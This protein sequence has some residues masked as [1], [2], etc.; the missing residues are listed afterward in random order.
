MG[1]V[2]SKHGIPV[3]PALDHSDRIGEQGTGAGGIASFSLRYGDALGDAEKK[4]FGSDSFGS[5]ESRKNSFVLTHSLGFRLSSLHKHLEGELVAAGW[6]AW[7]SAVAGEAIHGWVPRR[8]DSF[9]KLDKI[10]QGTYSNVFRA[11]EVDTG[12]IVALKKVRFDIHEPESVRFMAREIQILRRLDH[13]NIVKLEGLIA[14][15]LSCSVYLVF[16]YMDHDLAGLS[17]CPNIQFSESQVKCYMHQLLCGLE[18]CHSRGVMHRDIKCAN[19]LVN[20]DGTL[21]IADFGLSNFWKQGK[22][23]P[24]TSRVVTLWYRPP[25]LLL[26]STDYGA[27]VDLWSVGCV[28][29]ELLLRKPILPGRTEVINLSYSLFFL[30]YLQ[31]LLRPY[32]CSPCRF[33]TY[34][35]NVI[36]PAFM[37]VVSLRILTSNLG[38]S[39]M[40]WVEQL[41]KIFKLCGSPPDEYWKKS[42]LPHATIFK[43]HQ[44]YESCLKDACKALP[45]SAFKLIETLLSVEPCKRGTATSALQSKYFTTVPYACEPSSLP[46]YAPNKEMDART[47]ELACRKRIV[48]KRGPDAVL[49]ASKTCKPPQGSNTL[50][51]LAPHAEELRTNTGEVRNSSL[52]LPNKVSDSRLSVDQQPVP[53]SKPAEETSHLKHNCRQDSIPF[54]GPLLVPPSGGFAWA[55]R[56]KEGKASRRSNSRS[57]S[58]GHDSRTV[59]PSRNSPDSRGLPERKLPG[60]DVIG[61]GGHDL[62]EMVKR[63]VMKQWTKLECPDSFDASD[64]FPSQDLSQA[65]YMKDEMSS[66]RSYM[67][68]RK[69][70]GDAVEFSGPLLHQSYKVDELLQKHERHIRQVVRKSWFQRGRNGAKQE[71]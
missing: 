8:A 19:I 71:K 49:R 40:L 21:K 60:E 16:E 64:F 25:E 39:S 18:H 13:P 51:N 43:P 52:K 63:A 61:A 27:S 24:L 26:G 53:A 56:L 11:R 31:N 55:K 38:F 42:K 12:K 6:P 45:A 47:R 15:R 29:A 17:S 58:R 46:R 34:I 30:V 7:L 57:S 9:E 62:T 41:H 65:T 59:T 68:Y 70:Q 10:G 33:I 44:L 23:H 5:T 28:F 66:R 48:G 2:A 54:S 67:N 4:S 22:K 1:C 32:T 37:S 14:S 20:N 50:S 36:F 69:D 3:N 35:C